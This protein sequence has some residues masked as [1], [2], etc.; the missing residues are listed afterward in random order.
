M[1]ITTALLTASF[2]DVNASSFTT[3][4]ITPSANLLVLAKVFT[5]NGVGINTPT[6]TG[7]GLTWVK[8]LEIRDTGDSQVLA[9]F[10][11]MGASPSAGQV[12][13][14]CGGQTAI[15]CY[16]SISEFAGIDTSGTDGSGAIVQSASARSEDTTDTGITV[17]LGA[18]GSANNAT[19]GAIRNSGVTV[20]PGTGFTEISETTGDSG[21][22]EVEWRADNDTSVDWSWASTLS[23]KIA[24]GIEI[25]AAV[26]DLSINK[27]ESI[28]VTDTPVMNL[29]VSI[30]KS[31]SIT[32]TEALDLDLHLDINLSDSI[33]VTD[34]P[35][36]LFPFLA[37][38]K[39][40]SITVT[41][42]PI[43]D[44]EIK[45]NISESVTITESVVMNQE[46]NINLSES[47]T[48]TDSPIMNLETKLNVSESITLTESLT[49]N[50]LLMPQPSE[51]I[52]VTD[53]SSVRR[54]RF[55]PSTNW[56]PQTIGGT[57][58]TEVFK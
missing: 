49:M 16:W 45:A 44:L 29:A 6:L 25:K 34:T 30:N 15:G 56:T 18:F 20:A 4:S 33:T 24:V 13:I 46:I 2:D 1:A 5:Q 51:S 55:A 32:V 11:A 38:D 27:S 39:S 12:T 8:I 50:L 53:T 26:T 17:T 28:T 35:T 19:Y 54:V 9:I 43:M 23:S 57:D 41:D 22:L 31:E 42:T 48:V 3:A 52:I 14:D 40:D 58:W 21:W 10:R 36:V 47:I 37:P 7:N